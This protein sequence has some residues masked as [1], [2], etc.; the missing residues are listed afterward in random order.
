M[1]SDEE[2]LVAQM[3]EAIRWLLALVFVIIVLTF[4]IP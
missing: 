4:G 1:M 2:M 3:E